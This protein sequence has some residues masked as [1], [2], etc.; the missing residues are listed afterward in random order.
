MNALL[1]WVTPRGWLFA[2]AE[3]KADQGGCIC[4]L[5]QCERFIQGSCVNLLHGSSPYL[6]GL[7][8]ASLPCLLMGLSTVLQV[9]GLQEAFR[10]INCQMC[11]HKYNTL[12][13]M[14]MLF[15]DSFSW[16]KN[17]HCPLLVQ[18]EYQST[19]IKKRTWINMLPKL[20]VETFILQITLFCH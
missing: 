13:G 18:F 6:Q 14:N 3:G 5:R 9:G 1:A 20:L 10:C 4:T 19:F 11:T 8:C 15:I 12:L 2:T 7:F 16:T 17:I